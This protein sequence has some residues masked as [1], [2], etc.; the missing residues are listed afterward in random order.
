MYY[1]FNI[2]IS[3][4]HIYIY[5]IYLYSVPLVSGDVVVLTTDGVLDNVY[6]SQVS[7]A[8]SS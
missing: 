1:I 6:E 4:T 2:Y 7:E 8:L 3:N 5:Y